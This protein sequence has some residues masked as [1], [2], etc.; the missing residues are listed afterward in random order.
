[1]LTLLKT[2]LIIRPHNMAA[3]VLSVGVGFALAGSWRG[4]PL[5]LLTAT[6]LAT[7]AGNV[8][9]DW[10][11]RDIDAINKPARPIPSG[12]VVPRAA[13]GLYAALLV[14]LAG[15]IWRLPAA[16]GLWIAGWAVLLHVYSWKAKRMYLAGNLLV[17]AV[18]SSAFP[19]GA[20]AAG[21]IRAGAV[22]AAFTFLFVLGRELV[23]DAEDAAGDGECG[24]R[25]VA[26]V[27]GNGRALGA[28]AAIFVILAAAIPVPWTVGMYGKAY[29]AGMLL[30]VLPVLVI[31]SI[32][33]LGRGSPSTVSLLL[34][35]GMF[36]GAVS[37]YLGSFRAGS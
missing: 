31:S 14:A 37:F 18:V 34:K 8:I 26:V 16:E 12:G 29:L 10:F 17:A 33:C 21:N 32:L 24:A 4:V 23:K 1:M 19:L 13:L 2:F 20:F 5:C 35:I 15:C 22:P 11:D 3:A 7:A 25:T 28:A 27:S 6:A 36:F 30:S 9:N